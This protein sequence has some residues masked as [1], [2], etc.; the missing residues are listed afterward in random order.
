MVKEVKHSK[1]VHQKA[2]T[3]KYGDDPHEQSLR[4]EEVE[5]K[6]ASEGVGQ[7]EKRVIA[8]HDSHLTKSEK[9]KDIQDLERRMAQVTRILIITHLAFPSVAGHGL[10]FKWPPNQGNGYNAGLLYRFDI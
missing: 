6:E 5:D 1:E 7:A 9:H 4:D 3:T 10:P 8:R 2:G